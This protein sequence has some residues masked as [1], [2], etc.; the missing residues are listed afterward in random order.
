MPTGGRKPAPPLA[1]YG[2][3]PEALEHLGLPLF[4]VG[5]DRQ[6]KWLNAAARARFPAAE[7]A[8]FDEVVAP[9]SKVAVRSAFARKLLGTSPATE[10][11]AS[12]VQADGAHVRVEVNSVPLKSGHHIVG[13]FGALVVDDTEPMTAR[14]SPLTPRQLETLT[15]LARGCSTAQLAEE[16]GIAPETVRNHVRELLRKLGVHS[17]LEAVL[18]A[19]E[20]GLV[21]GGDRRPGVRASRS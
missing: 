9:E 11:R 5:A 6:V 15:L 18:M 21:A 2:D 10:Y 16:M 14:E 12:F 4:V 1:S 7:G 19:R 3:L 20:R 8:H 13:V 17:R